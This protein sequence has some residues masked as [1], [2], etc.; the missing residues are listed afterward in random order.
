MWRE[1]FNRALEDTR[2]DR[3]RRRD[4]T[5][6]SERKEGR[7]GRRG[8]RG[9]WLALHA[10]FYLLLLLFFPVAGMFFHVAGD[11]PKGNHLGNGRQAVARG[12][13]SREVKNAALD[14]STALLV[15][16][17]ARSCAGPQDPNWLYGRCCSSVQRIVTVPCYNIFVQII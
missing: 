11:T 4:P 14:L 10:R 12:L 9:P 7:G 13:Q 2:T 17:L 1:G 8:G 15:A 6:V 3:K 5:R 16:T